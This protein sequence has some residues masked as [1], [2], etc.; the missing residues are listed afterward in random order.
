MV[1]FGVLRDDGANVADLD[2]HVVN[3]HAIHKRNPV[4]LDHSAFETASGCYHIKASKQTYLNLA[5]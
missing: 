1:P 5:P 3:C 2:E 4:F